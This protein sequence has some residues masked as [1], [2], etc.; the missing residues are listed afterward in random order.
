MLRGWR[1]TIPGSRPQML[2]AL[3]NVKAGHLLD[4]SLVERLA[5]AKQ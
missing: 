5:S 2:A 1:R 4:R 3:K